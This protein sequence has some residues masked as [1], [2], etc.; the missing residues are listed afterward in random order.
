MPPVRRQ[1]QVGLGEDD[2]EDAFDLMALSQTREVWERIV[3]S[4]IGDDVRAVRALGLAC[5]S[6]SVR[7]CYSG[8]TRAAR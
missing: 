2:D 8:T 3:G 5:S 7:Q 4:L 6:C 1:T